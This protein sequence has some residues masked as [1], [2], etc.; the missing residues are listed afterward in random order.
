MQHE[1][2]VTSL[3]PYGQAMG[4][5][6]DRCVHCGLCLP[7]C[8]TYTLLGEEMD[9]PRGRIFLMK[10]ALEGNLSTAEVLPYI[11]RCLGC[12]A[13]TTAC[14]SGVDYGEL[15]SPFRS[16]AEGQRQRPAIDAVVRRLIRETLPYPD[17]FRAA[18]RMGKLAGPAKRLAPAAIA[19]L[20]D[21][22]PEQLPAAAALPAHIPAQGARR[23]RVALLTGCV[24]QALSPDI[25][26]ATVR[27]L[28]R[29]GVEVVV[30]ENQGCCGSLSMHIGD[31]DQARDLARRNIRAFTLDVDAII[32]NAAGCGSG[33]DEYPLLFSQQVDH[34]DAKMFSELTSDISVFLDQL[35]IEPPPDAVAPTRI[36]YHDA[37]HLA[38]A[39]GVTQEPRRL[40]ASIPGVTLLEIPEG[41]LCCGSAGI[42]NLEQ[43][44]LARQLGVRKAEN[45]LSTRPDLIAT[46]NIGCMVQIQNHANILGDPLPVLHT[47]EVLDR[48]YSGVSLLDGGLNND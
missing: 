36:A 2:P 16:L 9:S 33:I 48:A 18:Y 4:E 37:C 15:L 47:I 14:P 46:G 32:T 5:A 43:P 23:A 41:D 22:L 10:E 21:L 7:V 11:D 27:V 29:N 31:H 6:V 34:D 40:I 3:G 45:A 28:T 24:Q 19:P 44:E 13:C 30:P 17:R 12:M 35:G 26:W 1:I 39:Q 42:Y 20:F 38:H 8:P 25:N